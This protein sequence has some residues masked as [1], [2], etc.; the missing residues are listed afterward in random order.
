[1]TSTRFLRKSFLFFLAIL[2]TAF[3]FTAYGGKENDTDGGDRTISLPGGVKLEMVKI[4]AGNFRRAD[5]KTVRLTKSY[6]LGKYEVTNEQWQAVMRGYRASQDGTDLSDPSS[7][8]G[9]KRPVEGVSWNDAMDFC[10]RLNE[11][12]ADKLPRGYRIDLPTEAQWEY[13]C[14]A[15]TTTNYSYGNASDT[16]KMNFDGNNPYGGGS[17]GVCRG[18]TVDVGSL[19]Y[20]NAFGLY[21][22]HGNVCEW[23]RDWFK[24][25]GG[26]TADPTGPATGSKRVNRGG[27][28][29][30]SAR[31]C[32][33]AFRD[34]IDPGSRGKG[35]GCR[36]ALVP[37]EGYS[38]G[39]K[40]ARDTFP[41]RSTSAADA[42][43][44]S[45]GDRTISLPGGV[46]MEMVRLEA[47][48]F[49][50]SARDGEN[51]DGEVAHRATL[52]RDFCI[53]RT[54]VTQAQW[55][56]VMGTNP[57]K[58]KGDDLPVEQVSWNDAMEFC[59]KLNDSGKAPR[60]WKFTLP[61][62]TQW[63]YAA[64]GGKKSKGY[65][66][67]GSDKADDVAWYDANSGH[68]THPVGQKKANEIGLYDM[69][70]NVYEWCLDDSKKDSSKLTA[71]FSR[72]N[73]RSSSDRALRGGCWF[74]NARY[75]R[76]A[77]G[78]RSAPGDRGYDIGFRVAL[79]PVQ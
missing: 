23:C 39:S 12:Y 9:A 53:G 29:F 38:S 57:S 64:R 49:E 22:M 25:Y 69:S 27:G 11:L 21:D 72:G 74:F 77:C 67:S 61:T 75:C 48:S 32:R 47:G 17:K 68:K 24:S 4:P 79:V 36:L 52:K 62:E 65:K 26:D 19:G 51:F 58:F 70:G 43:G 33:S 63:E 30:S 28:W 34:G 31:D 54:E 35:L 40:A 56:A 20:K 7:R 8:K 76:S 13:A 37:D 50:M 66:Y 44:F 59:E 71:E 46:S 6:W 3:V 14:R 55:R 41:N 45:G 10:K 1:M 16:D 15:G 5:G 73:D 18:A 60:G 2:L 42:V 78:G